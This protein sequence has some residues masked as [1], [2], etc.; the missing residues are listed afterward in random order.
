MNGG[1]AIKVSIFVCCCCLKKT[2]IGT[3]G[4]FKGVKME[5]IVSLLFFC[6]FTIALV[7]FSSPLLRFD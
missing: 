5:K 1:F 6:F 2:I 7:S 4:Q 3:K